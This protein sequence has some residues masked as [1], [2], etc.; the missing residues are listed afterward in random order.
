MSK[1][2]IYLGEVSLGA[3]QST[4]RRAVWPGGQGMVAC[5]DVS[6]TGSGYLDIRM[7][8]LDFANG[9]ETNHLL[10]TV[11]LTVK[12]WGLFTAPKCLIEIVIRSPSA[13]A[14]DANVAIF[15]I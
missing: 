3:D 4:T 14:V 2:P 8:N 9:S 7:T 12:Q 15:P 11:D 13:S 5:D 10:E 6:V 1:T